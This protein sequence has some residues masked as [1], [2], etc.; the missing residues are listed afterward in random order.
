MRHVDVAIIGGS[1]AGAACV[2]E[3][4]RLGIT[5]VAFER[6]LF[7]RDKVCGGFLS[8]GATDLLDELG[9]LG[10]VRAAGATTVRSSTISMH[11]RRVNVEL[12]RPGLGV[13]RRVLDATMADHPG[14]ERAAVRDVQESKDGFT[15]RLDGAQVRAKIVVDAAGKLSRFTARRA[16]PQFGVQFYEKQSRG[17]VLDFSFFAEGYGGAVSVEGER[18]SAC[19]LIFKDALPKFLE[20]VGVRTE[21]LCTGPVAY[22]R[23]PSGFIAIGDAAGMI[24]PFC[25]EGMRHALDTGILAARTIAG[26]LHRGDSYPSMRARYEQATAKRWRAKRRLGALIRYMLQHPRITSVGF[27]LKPE[28]WFRQLWA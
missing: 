20:R 8:P 18:A 9:M 4:T 11:G 27:R 1:L 3:L 7:P 25:G 22:D 24:D 15:V 5:A 23:L 19:F 12:P 6:D 26:G 13:S 2:R 17:N 16:V 14:V 21:V 10:A 28:F